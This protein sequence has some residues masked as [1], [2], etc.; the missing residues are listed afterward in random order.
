M[1]S[2]FCLPVLELD[3]ERVGLVPGALGTPERFH[4][5]LAVHRV[6]GRVVGVLLGV[7][8]TGSRPRPWATF[9]VDLEAE[10]TLV[11][12]LANRSVTR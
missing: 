6:L 11:P 8:G 5:G 9:V 2:I 7:G 4:H 10:S 3:I 1:S 12:D